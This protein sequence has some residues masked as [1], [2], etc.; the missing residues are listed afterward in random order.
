MKIL[1]IYPAIGCS[2]G[3]NHGL[4]SLS[5]ILKANGHDTKL[6]YICDHLDQTPSINDIL[7]IIKSYQPGLVGFSAMSQQYEWCIK[8]SKSLKE[9]F[10]YIPHIIG[11]PHITMVPDDIMEDRVWDFI[12]PG[13]AEYPLLELV[14]ALDSNEGTKNIRSLR[15]RKEDGSYIVNPISP[16][17]NLTD[18]PP[19]DYDLFYVDEIIEAKGGWMSLMTSRGCPYTCSF[20][21]NKE[22]VDLYINQGGI[23]KKKEYLRRYPIARIIDDIQKLVSTHPQIN[24]FIFDDDLFTLDK[25]Y[26]ND[27][28]EAYKNA[29][30]SIPFV[31]NAHVQVFDENMASALK[32]A[33]CMILKFGIE[34]GSK[35]VRE[36]I[37]QRNMSNEKIKKALEVAHKYDLHTS[38]FIMFGLPTETKAEIYETLKLCAEL[39]LGRFR[40]ALFFPFPGTKAFKIADELGIIN[41]ERM[42]QLGSYFDGTCLRFDEEHELFLDKLQTFAHWWVNSF[43]DWPS[44]NI[45]QELVA[46]IEA[47][48]RTTWEEEKNR[49]ISYDKELSN[50]LLAEKSL[51]YANR[52]SQVMGVRSDFVLKDLQRL[53]D[54]T[55]T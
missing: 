21:F 38:G 34:S 13:E 25:T 23:K 5:G 45:Y 11:G 31:I 46:E 3:V 44:A 47:M 22:I 35:R 37:M 48:D 10:P 8:I 4:I 51:H 12:C 17:P 36:E 18:L 2:P 9:A 33:G 7:G 1:F 42:H 29:E 20:C 55:Q 30:I 16:F 53:K 19:F 28:C 54:K 52:F 40:W 49:L 24:V 50:S 14:N 26:V 41:F 6:I 27:F 15:I 39:K 32:E 43:T